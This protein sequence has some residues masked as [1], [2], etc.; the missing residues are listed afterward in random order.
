MTSTHARLSKRPLTATTSYKAP[1]T[2]I[3]LQ[4]PSLLSSLLRFVPWRTFL[5]LSQ[6]CRT[7]RNFFDIASA[8]S[9]IELKRKINARNVVLTR[10]VD[11][12]GKVLREAGPENL[13]FREHFGLE[14]CWEDL[15]LIILSQQTPLHTYPTHALSILTKASSPATSKSHHTRAHLKTAHLARL[16]LAHSRFVLI[17]QAIAHSSS[18]LPPQESDLLVSSPTEI[19]ESYR[20]HNRASSAGSVRELVFPAPLAHDHNAIQSSRSMTDLCVEPLKHSD[21]SR[22]ATESPSTLSKKHPGSIAKSTEKPWASNP[23]FPASASTPSISISHSASISKSSKRFSMASF[24]GKSSRLPPPPVGE[25]RALRE[26]SSNFGWRRGLN[27]AKGRWEAAVASPSYRSTSAVSGKRSSESAGYGSEIDDDELFSTPRRRFVG[28][29][30]R[31]SGSESSLSEG[32][33]STTSSSTSASNSTSATSIS[34]L[35]SPP[36]P[37]KEPL[38]GAEVLAINRGRLRSVTS[39]ARGLRPKSIGRSRPPSAWFGDVSPPSSAPSRASTLS[40][41]NAGTSANR[42]ARL[43]SIPSASGIPGVDLSYNNPHALH[44][45]ASRIRAPV[46]R[47][48][49]PSSDMSLSG[50]TDFMPSSRNGSGVSRCEEELFQAGL[51]EHLSVGDVV[52]NFGYVPPSS[53]GSS[54]AV[55]LIF[56][57]CQ[58][59]PFTFGAQDSRGILPIYSTLEENNPGQEAWMLPSWGYYEHILQQQLSFQ[60]SLGGRKAGTNMNIRILIS[61]IPVSPLHLD[62]MYQPTLLSIPRN[63][64]SP[65]TPGGMVVVKKWVWIVR[66]WVGVSSPTKLFTAEDETEL[67]VGIGWEGEWTLEG[68]GTKEGREV[69]LSCLRQDQKRVDLMEWELVR[70]RCGKGKVWLRLLKSSV[71]TPSP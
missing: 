62:V 36:V 9:E 56:N 33:S 4:N 71:P 66:V 27:D 18:N 64:P 65:H 22:A 19:A 20:S 11:G 50:I 59:V 43:R 35:D 55:W 34:A 49:I 69:L 25:P 58:L 26:Y 68:D 45:A 30:V 51:W 10:Y 37:P 3:F 16:T 61:K 70:D 53:S 63:I 1:L 46:L 14:L 28:S 54:D 17:L 48:F 24:L 7:W 6:T 52:C 2:E 23:S 39:E 21:H 42:R 38:S 31:V 57:G 29:D 15:V 44:L 5:A 47:V 32:T 8:H 40:P 12:F 60:R 13:A 67:E 41:G